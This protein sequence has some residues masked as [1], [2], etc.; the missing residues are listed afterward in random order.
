[1]S[2]VRRSFKML[3]GALDNLHVKLR[4]CD[5]KLKCCLWKI[6]ENLCEIEKMH[7]TEF[8]RYVDVEK[9]SSLNRSRISRV[10]V[11]DYITPYKENINDMIEYGSEAM[12]LMKSIINTHDIEAMNERD[13]VSNIHSDFKNSKEQIMLIL[14]GLTRHLEVNRDQEIDL[15]NIK[16]LAET[17]AK[18]WKKFYMIHMDRINKLNAQFFCLI[19]TLNNVLPIITNRLTYYGKD[20]EAMLHFNW[21]PH[22]LIQPE[23]P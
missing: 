12:K 6:Y 23:V 18:D 10:D 13:N 21:K 3:E 9:S 8:P 15:N 11:D 14:N 5:V 17:T 7:M 16:Q 22:H 20:Y 1:M 19:N 2:T 4:F